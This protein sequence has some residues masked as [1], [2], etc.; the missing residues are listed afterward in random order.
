MLKL[1]KLKCVFVNNVPAASEHLF[2]VFRVDVSN[3]LHQ[4]TDNIALHYNNV[5]LGFFCA[6][7]QIL[8]FHFY[9]GIYFVS[10]SPN[11]KKKK[12]C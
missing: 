11:R 9:T 3:F 2:K 1:K 10:S 7:M 8:P 5:F 12:V 4:R 6:I